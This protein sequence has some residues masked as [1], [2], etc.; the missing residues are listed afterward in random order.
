MELNFGGHLE[1]K[2]KLGFSYFSSYY[3][4]FLHGEWKEL[5]VTNRVPVSSWVIE[6]AELPWTMQT[7][8]I[9][10]QMVP[11]VPSHSECHTLILHLTN[12]GIP[13]VFLGPYFAFSSLI[14][15]SL[16]ELKFSVVWI[17][18]IWIR[19][20]FMVTYLSVQISFKRKNCTLLNVLPKCSHKQV[21]GFL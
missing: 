2:Q 7:L 6:A 17:L 18:H 4:Y 12:H 5:R 3:E 8:F 19:G 14:H 15:F 1:N 9:C 10:P 13:D 11:K 21:Q 20:S 16:I